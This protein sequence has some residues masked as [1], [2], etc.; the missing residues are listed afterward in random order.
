MIASNEI[1]TYENFRGS[2]PQGRFLLLEVKVF[3]LLM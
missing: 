3:K 1:A 2:D